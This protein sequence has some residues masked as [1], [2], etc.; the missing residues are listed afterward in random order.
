MT[1]NKFCKTWAIARFTENLHNLLSLLPCLRWYV[2]HIWLWVGH[3]RAIWD[4]GVKYRGWQAPYTDHCAPNTQIHYPVTTK[5][6]FDEISTKLTQSSGRSKFG[7]KYFTQSPYTDHSDHP[8]STTK[9][10]SSD[11]KKHLK[12]F[13]QNGLQ[14]PRM[15]EDQTPVFCTILKEIQKKSI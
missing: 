5:N 1:R 12:Y 8:P 11:N 3:M 9:Y 6:T 10:Y 15:V 13:R 4:I 14:Y 2:T 7:W